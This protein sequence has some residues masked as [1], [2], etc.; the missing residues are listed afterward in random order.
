MLDAAPTLEFQGSRRADSA[1]QSLRLGRGLGAA[2]AADV[3]QK[4]DELYVVS[5]T[6][7]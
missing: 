4:R 5:N 1:L 7:T 2:D 3:Q 6:T